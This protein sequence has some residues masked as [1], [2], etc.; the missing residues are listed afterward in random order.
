MK[1]LTNSIAAGLALSLVISWGCAEPPPERLV[2]VIDLLDLT[3]VAGLPAD[4][5]PPSAERRVW[6]FDNGL[7]EDWSAGPEGVQ[8]ISSRE[9]VRLVCDRGTPW[10]ELRAP[11]DPLLYD[12][13]VFTLTPQTRSK[14]DL[15]FSWKEPGRYRPYGLRAK[16]LGPVGQERNHVF[17]IPPPGEAEPSVRTLRLRIRSQAPVL[18]RRAVLV[19]RDRDDIA[20]RI[21]NRERIP[22]DQELKRCWRFTGGGTREVVFTVPV[23]GARL[24]F[25]TGTLTGGATTGRFVVEVDD[26][27]G[28]SELLDAPV[29]RREDGWLDERVDLH[30]WAGRAVTLRFRVESDD[31]RAVHLIGAPH[32]LTAEGTERPN[33]L[34]ILVDTL[35]ADHL[36]GYGHHRRTTPHLDRLSRQ[37]LLF[38]SAV[39]PA[40]WTVPSVAAVLTGHYP[41]TDGIG[42][43]R[44]AGIPAGTPTLAGLLGEAGYATAGFSANALLDTDRGYELGFRHYFC[45]PHTDNQHTAG[46]LNDRALRWLERHRDERFFCFLQYMDP[47]NPYDAP[48]FNPAPGGTGSPTAWRQGNVRM[49]IAGEIEIDRPEDVEQVKDCYDEE[50]SHVDQQIGRLLAQLRRLDLLENTLVIVSADHGE[51]LHDRGNWGH[52][53]TLYEELI[54]VPLIV[55]LPGGPELSR[56][57]EPLPVSLVDI[58][59]T[60]GEVAGLD[61]I[62]PGAP[63]QSLLQPEEDR[64]LR[65]GI[66]GTRAPD[67]Y[68]VSRGPHK[69]IYLNGMPQ[70]QGA[71]NRKRL[72]MVKDAPGDEMFF[73]LERDPG[74][75]HNLAGDAPEMEALLRQDLFRWLSEMGA[76]A[77]PPSEEQGRIDREMEEKLR[78]MGYMKE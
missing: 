14:A 10:L 5:Q 9:G 12:R 48:P 76:T 25:A 1:P 62:P 47:H 75:R 49:L 34:L 21:L 41:G 61:L 44:R 51:E 59:P 27:G 11:V 40:S 60:I 4:W 7:P 46:E 31:P 58:L 22:L 32:V 77:R 24:A 28:Y 43:G 64:I 73:H 55:R 52:G 23:S 70:S 78:A 63:G 17:K 69:Y 39:T 15:Q 53:F 35:R 3:P 6:R 67:F 13:L 54:R 50:I 30:R 57:R 72:F 29:A 74:E 33:V 37:G 56:G 45:T 66:W 19:P 8:L 16:S 38:T 26:G 2:P 71:R 20:T 36:S 42:I 18:L 65:S 68:A